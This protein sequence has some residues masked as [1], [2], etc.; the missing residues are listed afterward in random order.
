MY[1][2]FDTSGTKWNINKRAIVGNLFRYRHT[3]KYA[4]FDHA[5]ETIGNLVLEIRQ[6]ERKPNHERN[7]A[8]TWEVEL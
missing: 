5:Q 7:E 6:Q 3:D 1:M 8:H 2:G 4:G